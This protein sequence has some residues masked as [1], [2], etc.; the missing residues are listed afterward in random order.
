MATSEAVSG[1]VKQEE[2][3]KEKAGDNL[4][5]NNYSKEQEG[6]STSNPRNGSASGVHPSIEALTAAC[7]EKILNP[8]FLLQGDGEPFVAGVKDEITDLGEIDLPKPFV[9][10]VSLTSVSWKCDL[11]L[12]KTN[13]KSSFQPGAN[14]CA[15]VPAVTASSSTSDSFPR[16]AKIK[17]ARISNT[18]L[19]TGLCH[20]EDGRPKLTLS[21]RKMCGLKDLLLS[22][23]LNTQAIS[24]QL[25]AQSQV[26]VGRKTRPGTQEA[27]TGSRPKRTRRE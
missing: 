15:I 8:D 1:E 11:L 7:S 21:S 23:K 13:H 25:T 16:P 2:S 14:G 18:Y 3:S 12:T 24:L 10:K 9:K 19:M 17:T 26:Q 20:T 6:D 27:S 4:N 5:N 22:E